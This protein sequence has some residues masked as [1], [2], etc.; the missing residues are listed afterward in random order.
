MPD[1][2]K[3][4]GSQQVFLKFPY[5]RASL[6]EDT[7]MAFFITATVDISRVVWPTACHTELGQVLETLIQVSHDPFFFCKVV[8]LIGL[9][10]VLPCAFVP[11][12]MH[13]LGGGEQTHKGLPNPS[14]YGAPRHIFYH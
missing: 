14:F 4:V 6:M 3:T 8:S 1:L 12:R 7:H 9:H 10:L 5:G 2:Q 11:A 13:L